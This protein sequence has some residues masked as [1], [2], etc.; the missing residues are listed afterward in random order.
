MKDTSESNLLIQDYGASDQQR[1][2]LDA[3]DTL[4]YVAM[5]ATFDH[6]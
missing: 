6:I 4:D 3:V 1:E 2:H 5:F